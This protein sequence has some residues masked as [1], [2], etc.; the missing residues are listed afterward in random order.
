V[1]VAHDRRRHLDAFADDVLRGKAT[2]VD[3]RLD[4]VDED[5]ARRVGR[6]G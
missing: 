1:A 3:L 6:I 4:G 5:A 2:A